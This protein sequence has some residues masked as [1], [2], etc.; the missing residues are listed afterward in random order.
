MPTIGQQAVD[1]RS[2][3][4]QLSGREFIDRFEADAIPENSFHHADH[5]RLAFSYLSQFPPLEALE[6]FCSALKR[7]AAA[8]GKAQVYHETISHAYFFLIRERIERSS[9]A[10]WEEFAGRN[11]DLLI[12]ENGILSRYYDDAT[13][14][15]ELARR[16]FVMPDKSK[17]GV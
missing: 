8:R 4:I 10:A 2:A 11:P 16:I 17:P 7:F 6:R 14:K 15:S 5:V 9:G 13:L 1:K 3:S 12:W